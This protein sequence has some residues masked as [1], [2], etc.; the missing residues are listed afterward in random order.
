LNIRKESKVPSAVKIFKRRIEAVTQRIQ[1]RS[2]E[3]EASRKWEGI[4]RQ[5]KKLAGNPGDFS[6]DGGRVCKVKYRLGAIGWRG[7]N[8]T[9]KWLKLNSDRR[10]T[11]KKEELGCWCDTARSEKERDDAETRN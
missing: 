4:R 6:S 7:K 8:K 11:E 2:K 3:R 5:V 9:L 10:V 1:Y